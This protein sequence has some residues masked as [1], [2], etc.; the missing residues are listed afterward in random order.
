MNSV[1][2]IIV[3]DLDKYMFNEYIQNCFKSNKSVGFL[4]VVGGG[5][6]NVSVVS[7]SAQR[8]TTQ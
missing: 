6:V 4:L 2:N 3:S 8:G 5:R 1:H 7:K